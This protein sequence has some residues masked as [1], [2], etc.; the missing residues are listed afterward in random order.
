MKS[1]L[2]AFVLTF[3]AGMSAQAAY[4][5]GEVQLTKALVLERVV[6][7]K[8]GGDFQVMIKIEP[9]VYSANSTCPLS[10]DATTKNYILDVANK[11]GPAKEFENKK[12]VISGVVVL[13]DGQL[14]L[15]P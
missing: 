2:S 15:E 13:K 1:I 10:Y 7:A 14:I 12:A 6:V 8:P 3:V 11:S 5:E 4:C 9:V